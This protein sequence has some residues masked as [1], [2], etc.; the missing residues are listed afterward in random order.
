MVMHLA[1]KEKVK[2]LEGSMHAKDNIISGLN[3]KVRVVLIVDDS[4]DESGISILSCCRT[5][6]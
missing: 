6:S 5:P 3:Q 1:L 2:K 4:G